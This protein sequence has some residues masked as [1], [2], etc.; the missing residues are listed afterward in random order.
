MSKKILCAF[1]V[2]IKK[3]VKTLS[4]IYGVFMFPNELFLWRITIYSKFIINK[5]V[6]ISFINFIHLALN[7]RF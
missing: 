5:I 4:Q 3:Q 6:E 7:K 2:V 1:H